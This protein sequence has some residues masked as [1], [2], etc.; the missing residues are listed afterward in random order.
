MIWQLQ[1]KAEDLAAYQKHAKKDIVF[2]KNN[3]YHYI[4]VSHNQSDQLCSAGID[5]AG[6][7][8]KN[9]LSTIRLPPTQIAKAEQILN[10]N[11]AKKDK[12]FYHT[13]DNI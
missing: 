6:D 1:R 12:Y 11:S 4:N 7:I 5:V 2:D 9:E 3:R 13:L 10:S 8:A